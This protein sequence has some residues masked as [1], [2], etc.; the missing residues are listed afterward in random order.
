LHPAADGGLPGLRVYRSKDPVVLSDVL[1]I[2]EN[3]GLRVI[4]EEPFRIECTDGASVWIHE[5]QLSGIVLLAAVSLVIR[6]RFEETFVAVWTGRVENDGFNRLVLA[7][8]LSARQITVLRL[9]AKFLR[10]AGTTYSQGYMEDALGSHP[11]IARRLVQLFEIRFD[12]DRTGGSLDGPAEIPAVGH[13]LGHV[14]RLAEGPILRTYLKLTLKTVRTNYYQVPATADPKPYLAVKLASSEIELLPPP[15]PLF[16]I[17]VCSP[18]VEGLH[19]RAGK[20]A[21]GGIRWSDRRE[22]FRT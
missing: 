22:D 20:V 9:Y 12:P 1:P 7:A 6:E 8:G 16:E 2:L 17:Y 21:R 3:L 15:H 13:S 5:F 11:E 18:R 14:S 19:M 4:A 10:Q